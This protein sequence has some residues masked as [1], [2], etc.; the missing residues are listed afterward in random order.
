[1][2]TEIGENDGHPETYIKERIRDQ[3]SHYEKKREQAEESRHQLTRWSA[4]LMD[5][6]VAVGASGFVMALHPDSN[7]WL[8]RL[9]GAWA[10]LL[11][12]IAGLSLPL[13]L[14]MLQSL[15]M[16]GQSTRRTARYTQQ[17]LVLA[18][19]DRMLRELD[20]PEAQIN[21]VIRRTEMA[22]LSE[23]MEW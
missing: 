18:E 16:I 20:K 14:L 1:M 6:G 10:D 9:G 22:L 17:I 8:N 15:R 4:R 7:D 13:G 19:T 5:L 11:F 2:Q 23:V 21:E 12:G 3:K